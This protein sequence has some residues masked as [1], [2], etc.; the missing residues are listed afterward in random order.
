MRCDI[1]FYDSHDFKIQKKGEKEKLKTVIIYLMQTT[2]FRVINFHFYTQ[3]NKWFVLIFFFFSTRYAW[4]WTSVAM[5]KIK[6]HSHRDINQWSTFCH[7][8]LNYCAN[9]NNLL[10]SDKHI[11]KSKWHSVRVCYGHTFFFSIHSSPCGVNSKWI[12]Y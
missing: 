4:W 5:E 7:F 3:K 10:S 12:V 9:W 1:H 8:H 2:D 11:L 6:C